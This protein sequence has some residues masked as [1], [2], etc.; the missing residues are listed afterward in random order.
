[1]TGAHWEIKLR[2][3]DFIVDKLINMLLGA[4]QR[5]AKDQDR[6]NGCKTYRITISEE[7]AVK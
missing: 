4:E 5:N 1:M 2:I 7:D 3:P 6:T